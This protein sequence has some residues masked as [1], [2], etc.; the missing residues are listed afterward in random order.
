MKL[1]AARKLKQRDVFHATAVYPSF[2]FPREILRWKV[3]VIPALNHTGLVD[4][5]RFGLPGP[6]TIASNVSRL[7]IADGPQ[8]GPWIR[9]ANR[10]FRFLLGHLLQAKIG[11]A[12]QA[13]HNILGL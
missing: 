6:E 5:V 9:L 7:H 3:P 2:L 10:L 13:L 11:R 1:N 4:W 12:L 8:T